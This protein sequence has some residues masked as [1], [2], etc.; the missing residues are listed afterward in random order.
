M[1]GPLSRALPKAYNVKACM[2]SAVP[3]DHV[4]YGAVQGATSYSNV[5]SMAGV[6]VHP[7]MCAMAAARWG[8]RGG[9]G[10]A[11][12][13]QFIRGVGW[14]DLVG[15]WFAMCWRTGYSW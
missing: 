1:L 8:R 15:R 9:G 7:G 12:G 5:P 2:L 4:L 3:R 11:G 14:W 6:P 13:D 10:G